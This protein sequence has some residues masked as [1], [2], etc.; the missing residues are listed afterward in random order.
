MILKLRKAGDNFRESLFYLPG[1]FVIGAVV[2]GETMILVDASVDSDRLPRFL[3]FSVD[4]ARAL[5]STVAG[6]TITVAGTVFALTAL[7]VQLASSQFS[8]R[9]LRG[10]LRDRFQQAAIGFMVGTFTY[11]LI[12]LR[13]VRGVEG[14]GSDVVPN[15]GTLLGLVLAIL[16]VFA[17]LAYVNRT[18]HS[19]QATSLIRRVTD[20]TTSLIARRFPELGEGR[21]GAVEPPEPVGDGL[22]VRALRTGWLQQVGDQSLLD[23]LPPGGVVR[24]DRRVGS[25]VHVGAR[26][27]T[28]WGPLPDEEVVAREVHRSFVV[29]RERSMQ[30]DA[31][32]GIQQLV[33][34]ALRALS[35]GVNDV[36]TAYECIVHLGSI[37]HEILHRDLPPSILEGD[38]GR[39][40]L[41]PHDHDHAGYVGEAFDQIRVS[42]ASLPHLSAALINVAGQLIAE[43]EAAG[44]AER[45]PPLRQLIERCVAGVVTH[46]PL[47]SDLEVVE[48][49]AAA[50]GVAVDDVPEA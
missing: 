13:A 42:A 40:G 3:Q 2:L 41:C 47:P 11:S 48:R 15:L 27:A 4:N 30:Q 36:T 38:Q 6:A 43:L 29:G 14:E 34:I 33:D 50:A 21:S 39:R 44:L 45:T 5:L 49:A 9:V 8:P 22:V 10:F 23:A 25:F 31:G 7:T 35:T 28:V 20:E 26:L 16:A 32:F 37:L 19:L 24:V 46:E 17:I 1:I 18:V 12:I